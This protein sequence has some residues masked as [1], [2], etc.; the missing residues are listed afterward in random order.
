MCTGTPVIKVGG[1][2][3]VF[4]GSIDDDIGSEFYYYSTESQDYSTLSGARV[5]MTASEVQGLIPGATRGR[6]GNIADAPTVADGRKEVVFALDES[7]TV[8]AILGSVGGAAAGG[9]AC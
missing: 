2:R 8:V 3:L 4:M 9:E 6:A 7:E 1:L 5:G